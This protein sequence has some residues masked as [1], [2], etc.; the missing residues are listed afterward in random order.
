MQKFWT[1]ICKPVQATIFGKI[2]PPDYIQDYNNDHG[3]GLITLLNNI[4]NLMIVG[5]GIFA[6]FNFII[7]GYEFISA[8]GD[9]QK[10]NDAWNKIWQS[11]LG[12]IIVAG[13]FTLAAIFGKLIF[14][15]FGAIINPKI[16]GPGLWSL[17]KLMQQKT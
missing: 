9:S 14:N 17:K 1:L 7:A 8:G 16:K 12:L 3:S 13:S 11:I 6:L 2:K 15:D 4:L 10:I 5:A